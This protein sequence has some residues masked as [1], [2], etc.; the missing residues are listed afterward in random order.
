MGDCQQT[1]LNMNI[2]L[3]VLILLMIM[4]SIIALDF[5]TIP[6]NGLPCKTPK[7][8]DG[9]CVVISKCRTEDRALYITDDG[10]TT[11][12]LRD[13]ACGFDVNTPK[14]CCVTESSTT[15]PKKEKAAMKEQKCTKLNQ[16]RVKFN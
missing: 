2:I 14:I 10:R 5:P 6:P 7:E 16:I 9:S 13:S 3:Q 4:K 12:Y 1:H 11:Q 15:R 8:E